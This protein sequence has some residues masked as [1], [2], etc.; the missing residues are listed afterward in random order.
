MK[1]SLKHRTAFIYDDIFLKHNLGAKHPESPERLR[2]IQKRLLL[3]GLNDMLLHLKPY[4]DLKLISKAILSLHTKAHYNSVA[5]WEERALPALYAVGAVLRG[6]DAV[7]E[8]AAPQAFCAIRPPGHHAH[9]HGAHCD[10]RYQGEGFCFF[11]NVA[12]GARY[13]Q[14]HYKLKRIL[15]VD[16]D[17][18]HGNGTEYFFYEDPTVFY[19]S[20]HAQFDYPLTG[21]PERRGS[22]KGKGYN[23]NVP[24]PAQAT[25]QDFLDAFKAKLFPTLKELHFK[26]DLILISAGFDSR[27][28]DLLGCFQITDR[29]FNEAT[30]LLLDL[31]QASCHGR[32][33]SI[34]E[35]G[36]NPH[37]LSLAVATHL[38]AMLNEN[39]KLESP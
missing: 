13:A 4:Q 23:L 12:I 34:L 5:R 18:H 27:A 25:D 22:G 19:F 35:G 29:G 7:M 3:T 37:G 14:Q 17:Y 21:F 33:V 1:Q 38:R 20:T 6:I 8:Q 10:G 9:N 31:A 39:Q 16:W 32:I 24:L 2:A 15:I 28:D 11:N 36:Y 26:P 30:R